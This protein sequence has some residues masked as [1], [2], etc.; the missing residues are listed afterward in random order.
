MYPIMPFIRSD[1]KNESKSATPE[2]SALCLQF[3]C[4]VPWGIYQPTSATNL[5]DRGISGCENKGKQRCNCKLN[6]RSGWGNRQVACGKGALS[7]KRE[8]TR[9]Y[10]LP[11]RGSSNWFQET[12]FIC[13]ILETGR[14]WRRTCLK[15]WRRRKTWALWVVFSGLSQCCP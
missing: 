4:H 14:Q 2:T 12:K 1:Y 13:V 7:R 10:Q 9:F 5:A 3:G 8:L 6:L 11:H 15:E